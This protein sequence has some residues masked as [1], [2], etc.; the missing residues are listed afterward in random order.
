M[1]FDIY[2]LKL[3]AFWASAIIND[4][5]SGMDDNEEE[6]LRFFLFNLKKYL[7]VKELNGHW[8]IEDDEEALYKCHDAIGYVEACNC[9]I[10]NWMQRIEK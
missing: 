4:D 10:F 6:K 7:G 1:N 2:T 3:P 8:S 5:W 9:L